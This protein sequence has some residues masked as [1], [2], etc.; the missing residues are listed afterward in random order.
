MEGCD[1]GHELE[2]LI[3]EKLES[4]V[5]H[6]GDDKKMHSFMIS[7]SVKRQKNARSPL[8]C[9]AREVFLVLHSCKAK[10]KIRVIPETPSTQE[11]TATA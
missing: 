9:V 8:F 5:A 1:P 2:V 6:Y 7:V 11:S 3:P 10:R 4:V